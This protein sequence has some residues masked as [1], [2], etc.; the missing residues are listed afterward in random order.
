VVAVMAAVVEKEE[1]EGIVD[2]VGGRGEWGLE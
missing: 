1:E 2:M